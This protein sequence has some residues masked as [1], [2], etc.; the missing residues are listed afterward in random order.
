MPDITF[1]M[2][3]LIVDEWQ[4]E[5]R[6]NFIENALMNAYA[7][8]I[9]YKLPDEIKKKCYGCNLV[10]WA[11]GE[12]YDHPSQQMHNVCVMMDEDKQAELCFDDILEIV[13][14]TEELYL[15]WF[16]SLSELN[17]PVTYLE[18]IKYCCKDWRKIHWMDQLWREEI[19]ARIGCYY[20]KS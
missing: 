7:R 20:M 5:I 10:D 8:C 18:Y 9:A 3:D 17:P 1:K 16:E 14:D 12:T 6:M 4:K 15:F 13:D 19:I 2:A 11:S